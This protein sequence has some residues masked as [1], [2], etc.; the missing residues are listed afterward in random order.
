M[1]N[2]CAN[3]RA[4]LILFLLVVGIWHLVL[5]CIQVDLGVSLFYNTRSL[6]FLIFSLMVCFADYTIRKSH[7]AKEARQRVVNRRQD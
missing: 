4:V 2:L 5:A 3:I 6:I 1:C 7:Q